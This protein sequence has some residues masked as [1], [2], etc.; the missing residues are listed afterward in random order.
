MSKATIKKF[1]IFWD[2]VSITVVGTGDILYEK[3][4]VPVLKKIVMREIYPGTI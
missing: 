2:Y 4:M 1:I 3:D